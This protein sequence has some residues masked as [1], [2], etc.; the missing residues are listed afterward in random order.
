MDTERKP[1]SNYQKLLTDP[2]WQKRL[3]GVLNDA[4]W[5]CQDAQCGREDKT[6]EV[7]HCYYLYGVKPW[8]YPPDAFLA[9][10]EDCHETRQKLERA[11]KIDLLRSLRMVPICRLEKL[12]W[13]IVS[14]SLTE[15]ELAR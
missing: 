5:R 4:N 11:I 10:C 7:H 14:E 6:L 8:D 1:K 13:K 3:L 12:A 15:Q 9:L 2:R